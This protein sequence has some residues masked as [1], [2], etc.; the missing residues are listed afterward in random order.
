VGG[1]EYALTIGMDPVRHLLS[2]RSRLVAL[3]EEIDP[4][5][6]IRGRRAPG[7]THSRLGRPRPRRRP[8]RPLGRRRERRNG[9]LP[10]DDPR[11]P[12]DTARRSLP[13]A[14]RAGAAIRAD[15]ERHPD[16]PLADLLRA[17]LDAG[18][19][20]EQEAFLG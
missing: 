20:V 12:P 18:H 9:A 4:G 14:E 10:R 3:R 19:W 7:R 13:L 16:A 5:R 2:M 11:R 8:D 15:L 1:I 17:L 6:A